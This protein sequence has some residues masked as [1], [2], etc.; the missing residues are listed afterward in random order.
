MKERVGAH[1]TAV[2]KASFELSLDQIVLG[3]LIRLTVKSMGETRSVKGEDARETRWC[4][5]YMGS[6]AGQA[7]GVETRLPTKFVHRKRQK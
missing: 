6:N 7:P 5:P 1:Y 4:K 3:D 2:P